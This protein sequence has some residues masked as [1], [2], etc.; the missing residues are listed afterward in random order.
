[1][2]RTRER[3][4]GIVAELLEQGK[5]ESAQRMLRHMLRKDPNN[6]EIWW[7]LANTAPRPQAIA[8]VQEILRLSPLH[9]GARRLLA[10]LHQLPEAD[11]PLPELLA[12]RK[13]YACPQCAAQLALKTTIPIRCPFCDTALRPEDQRLMTDF[14]TLDEVLPFSYSRERAAQFVQHWLKNSWLLPPRLKQTFSAAW[15]IPVYIPFWRITADLGG[16]WRNEWGESG[17]VHAEVRDLLHSASAHIP[18]QHWRAILNFQLA[19]AQ[20]YT[21][22]ELNEFAVNLPAVPYEQALLPVRRLVLEALHRQNPRL[23]D[24]DLSIELHHETDLWQIILL[25]FYLITY[26]Y[27][28]KRYQ[29][30]VNGQT[31]ELDGGRPV[32]W[33]RAILYIL[34]LILPGL[35]WSFLAASTG[36]SGA[37]LLPLL[38][39]L[40]GL[41]LS[42]F[43]LNEAFTYDH[44]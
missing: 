20:A 33:R 25:P 2:E 26:S 31:G 9:E 10:H 42:G 5:D 22:A 39:L 37:L 29:I 44:P 30:V 43:V 13:I 8:A 41:I 38:I 32:E 14:E 21:P 17:E 34:L 19:H 1:M 15:L 3:E 12:E 27:G 11:R 6:V 35:L 4:L 24:P 18:A 40:G 16:T 28:G 7:V 23:D 36:V